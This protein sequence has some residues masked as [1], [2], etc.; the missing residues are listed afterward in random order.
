[1]EHMDKDEQLMTGPTSDPPSGKD[2]ILDT[3]IGTLLCLQT[4]AQNNCLLTGIIQQLM[5][6]DTGTHHQT[7]GSAQGA[8]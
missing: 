3:F 4:G 2:T 6:T 8:V 5:E 1:M 7:S